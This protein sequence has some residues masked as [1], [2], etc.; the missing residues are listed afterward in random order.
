MD[1]SNDSFTDPV[2]EREAVETLLSI[3]KA[4]SPQRIETVMDK[5]PSETD[6]WCLPG[7]PPPLVG[8]QA[9]MS[10]S[11][12]C[13]Q[14]VFPKSP[15][16]VLA[17]ARQMCEE[18]DQRS[19]ASS[20]RSL[21][22]S[23]RS[24]AVSPRSMETSPVEN[25]SLAS[26]PIEHSRLESLSTVESKKLMSIEETHSGLSFSD[27]P[28]RALSGKSKL[29]QL[30]MEGPV[31]TPPLINPLR[32]HPVSVIV[33]NSQVIIDTT[34]VN[35]NVPFNSLN[36]ASSPFIVSSVSTTSTSIQIA[37]N[38]F[39]QGK[40]GQNIVG[41]MKVGQSVTVASGSV[42]QRLVQKLMSPETVPYTQSSSSSFVGKTESGI[43]P[44][45]GC[46]PSVHS[47]SLSLDN[48]SVTA[49]SGRSTPINILPAG[50]Q[51]ITRYPIVV[52]N[53]NSGSQAP[54]VQVIVM[55]N[56]NTAIKPEKTAAETSGLCPI[57]PAV[58]LQKGMSLTGQTD[59]TNQRPRN[60][61]CPYQACDKTYFKSSHL[62]AHI[63]THT[64]EKPFHCT[65]LQCDR[66][67][68]RSD[69]L[70]RHKRTHTG[71]KNFTCPMCS[72]SF[73]RSDHLAKHIGRHSNG[74]VTRPAAR[75]PK[76][77]VVQVEIPL[78]MEEE[79]STMSWSA[80]ALCKEVPQAVVD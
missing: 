21:A 28:K 26:S 5:I 67:F 40:Q 12:S 37:V 31:E 66:K 4:P 35:E 71:E 51:Q 39:L 78:P 45:V 19:R 63:R 47:S 27:R 54:V 76:V 42:K 59:M 16:E 44:L 29:A 1:N 8:Q 18:I 2:M 79:D 10:V 74:T 50:I 80:E 30:L 73:V 17:M 68:A 25:G 36:S 15:N 41:P 46:Y 75:I 56:G 62:K 58:S 23:P 34:T 61:I 64:G 53:P 7:D 70:S 33:P 49:L 14:P 65:W 48:K 72:R 32:G 20:P 52:N 3:S 22:A 24:L 57:A 9:Q 55:N 43:K 77:G 69:E 6:P 60:H 13:Q 38:N 11:E